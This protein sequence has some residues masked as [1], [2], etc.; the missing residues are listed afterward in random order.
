MEPL[1]H[2]LP[3][4]PLLRMDLPFSVWSWSLALPFP[5]DLPPA[6]PP[7]LPFWSALTLAPLI[8]GAADLPEAFA[9][10]AAWAA[11]DRSFFTLFFAAL[12]SW[13]TTWPVGRG[14]WA[15]R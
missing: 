13:S 1:E 11:F 14:S 10:L 15:P 8:T 5:A 3:K 7:T 9:A 6:P 2:I 12:V 4:S